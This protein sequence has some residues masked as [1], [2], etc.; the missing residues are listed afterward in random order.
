MSVILPAMAEPKTHPINNEPT[1]HPNSKSFRLKWALIKGTAPE[2]MA[3]SKPKSNPPSA[4][5]KVM[6]IM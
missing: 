2:I 4:A 5:T 6:R 3:M 1:P